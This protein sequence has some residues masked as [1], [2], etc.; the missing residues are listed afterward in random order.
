MTHPL[1]ELADKRKL[2]ND[3]LSRKLNPAKVATATAGDRARKLS[4]GGGLYLYVRPKSGENG[5]SSKLWRYKY[6]IDARE[7]LFALGAMPEI[8]LADA[9]KIHRAARWLVKRKINPAQY[10]REETARKEALRLQESERTFAVVSARWQDRDKEKLTSGSLGQRQR[11]LKKHVL[12]SLGS[13]TIDTIRKDEL[14]ELLHGIQEAAPEVARN[15][16]QYLKG[17]FDY[18]VDA[19]WISGSPVPGPKVLRPRNQTPHC[20]LSL[21]KVGAFLGDVDAAGCNPQTKIATHLLLLTAVRK[22]ELIQAR[23]NEFDL[24]KADW[25]IPAGRMKM[26]EGHW[27]PLSDQAVSILEELRQLSTK[28]LLFPN[29]RNP[30]KPMAG[31]SI[32]AFLDRLGYLE[33][34]KPHGFR[35]TFSTYFNGAGWNPDVIEKCLAHKPQDS[36]RAKY[37]RAE[38]R[39]EQREVMQTWA[40]LIESLKCANVVPLSAQRAN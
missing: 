7:G 6:R 20:A 35:S 26:R 28:D 25:N 3:S 32:N 14:T 33:Q 31:R 37:N 22:Q 24:D 10:M 12:P 16:R 36:V 5:K 11:E 27:V 40:N 8:S 34:A 9:R 18:A 17:I 21:E 4:D 1:I 38:Y 39:E 13:K 29:V 15:V 19:G 23:W 2:H 30:G